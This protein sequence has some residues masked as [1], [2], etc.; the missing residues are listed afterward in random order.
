[1]P[2]EDLFVAGPFRGPDWDSLAAW[3]QIAREHKEEHARE[4][5]AW[6]EQVRTAGSGPE[7]GAT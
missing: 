2:D 1:M 4:I 6:R 3:L 5:R 7:Q